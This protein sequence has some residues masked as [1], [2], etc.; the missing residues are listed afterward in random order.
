MFSFLFRAR[1]VANSIEIIIH[2]LYPEINVIYVDHT[3]EA[4]YQ[5]MMETPCICGL[6]YIGH[7]TWHGTRSGLVFNQ[8]NGIATEKTTH[9]ID[10]RDLPTENLIPGNASML[11]ACRSR[12]K[13]H[14]ADSIAKKMSE[15][16]NGQVLGS[17]N[18]LNFT[19]DG[20]HTPENLGETLWN[21]FPETEP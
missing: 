20:P 17:E 14:G 13:K 5:A 1:S 3:R 10:V 8:R 19:S 6:I 4:V 21:V 2:K 18:K 7:A 9:S 11:I 12:S 15:H 16:F